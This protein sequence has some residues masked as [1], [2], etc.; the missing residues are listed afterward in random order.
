MKKILF[1]L[2]ILCLGI[3]SC[4]DYS[5]QII[6]SWSMTEHYDLD[7]TKYPYLTY[8]EGI[9]VYEFKKEHIFVEHHYCEGFRKGR[10]ERVDDQL[11]YTGTWLL[12]GDTLT[13]HK[14]MK[15]LR[16]YFGSMDTT[17][18]DEDEIFYIQNID[19]DSLFTKKKFY[20]SLLDVRLGRIDK[21]TDIGSRIWLKS[22]KTNHFP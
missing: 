14:Y 2:G 22:I 15:E 16:P 11:R 12:A 1:L 9:T 21:K 18:I 5:Q 4:N 10:L 20:K 17:T 7:S 3:V 8:L 13:V 6:G 19:Y